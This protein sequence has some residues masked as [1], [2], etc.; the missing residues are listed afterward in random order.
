MPDAAAISGPG[1]EREL[2]ERPARDIFGRFVARAQASRVQVHVVGG[3]SRAVHAPL[4]APLVAAT[5]GCLLLDEDLDQDYLISTVVGLLPPGRKGRRSTSSASDVTLTVRTSSDL[6]VVGVVG[7]GLLEMRPTNTEVPKSGDKESNSTSTMTSTSTTTN[8]NHGLGTFS[9]HVLRV[10]LVSLNS[11]MGW[12]ILFTPSPTALNR[13]AWAEGPFVIEVACSWYRSVPRQ[14]QSSSYA[15]RSRITRVATATCRA[16]KSWSEVYESLDGAAAGVLLA[17]QLAHGLLT[18]PL[19]GLGIEVGRGPSGL[20]SSHNLDQFGG[21]Q[22][23]HTDMDMMGMLDLGMYDAVAGLHL[24][25]NVG[26][27]AA[28]RS[29]A[30]LGPSDRSIRAAHTFAELSKHARGGHYIYEPVLFPDASRETVAEM[31]QAY[32]D[33]LL[34]Q[35]AQNLRDPELVERNAGRPRQGDGEGDRERGRHHPSSQHSRHPIRQ[36]GMGSVPEMDVYLQGD[37]MGREKQD[38]VE[39]PPPPTPFNETTTVG[40]PGGVGRQI[41]S[42]LSRFSIFSSFTTTHKDEGGPNNPT[43]HPTSDAMVVP[44]T[45][46]AY[47]TA[48]Y[49]ICH[50]PLLGLDRS[51]HTDEHLAFTTRLHRVAFRHACTLVTPQ[52]YR[53]LP[54]GGWCR[55]PP[56]HL[57]LLPGSVLVLDVGTDIVVWLGELAAAAPHAPALVEAALEQAAALYRTSPP[58]PTPSTPDDGIGI[59]IHSDDD[60]RVPGVRVRVA[61]QGDGPARYVTARLVPGHRDEES[62]WGLQCPP[63]REAPPEEQRRLVRTS[64]P[65]TDR[66]SWVAWCEERGVPVGQRRK[67]VGGKVQ[68]QVHARVRVDFEDVAHVLSGDLCPGGRGGGG[69]VRGGEWL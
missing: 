55:T 59:R 63:L 66:P 20:D 16:G 36:D 25:A 67:G 48:L 6:V 4:W 7:P 23:G 24:D 30:R 28:S 35:L 15:G 34:Q 2:L 57:A 56:S 9:S 46:H 52:L 38:E 29:P 61:R 60:G 18:L 43:D 21:T 1:N 14:C 11:D 69:G 65:P 58:G 47:L 53:M 17:K 3:G 37:F 22:Y 13:K 12:G 41:L 31:A 45:L 10:R 42:T 8:D 62:W 44:P 40:G 5:G 27:R 19:G 49:H 32:V 26:S 64:I 54:H 33:L 50:G 68:I 51:Q 39:D